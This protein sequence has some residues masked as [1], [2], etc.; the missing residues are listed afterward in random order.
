MLHSVGV[1]ADDLPPQFVHGRVVLR[2]P[3]QKQ[4]TY[5]DHRAG[6]D[7]TVHFV[8]MEAFVERAPSFENAFE[9]AW[10]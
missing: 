7:R 10:F 5:F 2:E 6:A 3:V 4:T 1:R 9:A 8:R